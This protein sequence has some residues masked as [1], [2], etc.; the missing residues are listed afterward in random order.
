MVEQICDLGDA[1]TGSLRDDL[2]A[3]VDHNH[4]PYAGQFASA[5][6]RLVSEAS[7]TAREWAVR[8]H[9]FGSPLADPRG[10]RRR[11]R[12]LRDLARAGVVQIDPEARL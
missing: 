11:A 4:R 9:D 12:E 2:I 3:M 5:A 6:L 7:M 1:D 10:P 8:R